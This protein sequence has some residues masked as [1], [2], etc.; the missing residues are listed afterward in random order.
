V[1]AD[2]AWDIEFGKR[3]VI[4]AVID[5]G[6]DYNHEDLAENYLASEY[7][8]VNHDNDLMDDSIIGHGTHVAGIIG[9]VT[10]NDVGIAG[11]SQVSIMAGKS[12]QYRRRHDIQCR[13]RRD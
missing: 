1:R 6:I 9:A 7:H 2:L 11:L 8:W 4:V 10:N 13:P 3:S 5:T 12:R